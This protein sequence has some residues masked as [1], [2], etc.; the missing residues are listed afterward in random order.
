MAEG[1]S[2]LPAAL[3]PEEHPARAVAFPVDAIVDVVSKAVEAIHVAVVFLLL[4]GGVELL[5]FN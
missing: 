5:E 1:I 4:I 3:V 2:R